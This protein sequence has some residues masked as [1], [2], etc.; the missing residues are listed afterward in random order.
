[1]AMN[2]AHKREASIPRV[3]RK[4]WQIA[5]RIGSLT[6]RLDMT[7][8]VI[9]TC[10]QI[11]RQETGMR[12]LKTAIIVH[13]HIRVSQ[14]VGDSSKVWKTADEQWRYTFMLLLWDTVRG[15]VW[16]VMCRSAISHYFKLVKFKHFINPPNS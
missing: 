11:Y 15:K 2:I 3:N 5:V 14:I 12:K 10:E 4:S 6:D 8:T 9:T 13:V 16:T 7:P 1:M